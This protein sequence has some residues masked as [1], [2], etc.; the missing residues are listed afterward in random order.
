MLFDVR[1]G[2]I[3]GTCLCRLPQPTPRAGENPSIAPFACSWL[4]MARYGEQTVD[5]NE[6]STQCIFT[7]IKRKGEE[8]QSK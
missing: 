5:A 2:L 4:A 8:A 6:I 7:R 1:C 3:V